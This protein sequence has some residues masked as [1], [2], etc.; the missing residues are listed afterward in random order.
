M[1]V[2]YL[3]DLPLESLKK[4]PQALSEVLLITKDHYSNGHIQETE[5]VELE[6]QFIEATKLVPSSVQSEL[7]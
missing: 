3:S 6:N 4:L 5:W 2:Y 1:W 7:A